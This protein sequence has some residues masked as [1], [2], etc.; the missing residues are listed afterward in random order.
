MPVL[1]TDTICANLTLER[2]RNL[3]MERIMVFKLLLDG[4]GDDLNNQA[5]LGGYYNDTIYAAYQNLTYSYGIY[6][7]RGDDLIDLRDANSG[8]TF[9]IYAGL[10]NDTVLGG[11]GRETA[12]DQSGSD[13]YR[14]GGNSDAIYIGKGNDI[15][16]GGSGSDDLFLSYL[17]NDISGLLTDNNQGVVVDL[18]I[19]TAQDF[20]YFGKDV[21][22]SFE[23]VYGSAGNDVITGTTGSNSL[24]G[25]DGNDFLRGRG[26][27]D[28]LFGSFGRDTL[29]GDSGGDSMSAFANDLLRDIFRYYKTSD[30]SISN[31]ATGFADWIFFFHQGGAATDDKIDLSRIDARVLTTTVNDAFV[32]EGT[33]GVFNSARGEI[34]VQ[35]INLG[36]GA[37]LDSII[38]IDTD[39]D[40]A[41]E[42]T[43]V[44][45]DVVGLQYYDFI[46]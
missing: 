44:V 1:N 43:I 35:E 17:T 45:I 6:T 28:Q 32:F 26:G 30:S 14:L 9:T 19:T 38:R 5:D 16:D 20:G 40:A 18:A 2:H 25:F 42:M 8:S 36:G 41:T 22:K 11:G 4:L 33:G 39:G 31:T 27:N 13:I 29:I 3:E 24:F 23:N 34:R 46:L 15:Y 21:V 12:I 7:Y 10:G 37:G